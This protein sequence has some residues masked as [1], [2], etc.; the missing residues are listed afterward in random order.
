MA[1]IIA[2]SIDDDL[3]ANAL[4][5]CEYD[6]SDAAG[7]GTTFTLMPVCWVNFFASARSRWWLPPTESPMNV[8]DCPP[9]L[10]LIAAAFGTGGAGIVAAAPAVAAVRFVPAVAAPSDANKTSS[11]IAPVTRTG[12]RRFMGLTCVSLLGL[13]PNVI[14]HHIG[15]ATPLYTRTQHEVPRQ[16][17]PR[18]QLQARTGHPDFLDLP[19]A[20][21]LEEWDVRAPRAR[22]ARDRPPRRALRR[23]RR[24]D[25]RAEGAAGRARQ[26]RV[27]AAARAGRV[28][29]SR[30]GGRGRPQTRRASRRC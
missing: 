13:Q 15:N 14:R 17:G 29:A 8:I 20:H 3:D 1:S 26:A 9:Y 7:C 4:A 21:P 25:L 23:L 28:G 10:A 6:A 11:P 22:R 27:P 24:G 16:W 19:W 18:L 5:S 12:R 2:T 30:G